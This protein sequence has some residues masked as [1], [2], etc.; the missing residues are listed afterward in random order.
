MVTTQKFLLELR[1]KSKAYFQSLRDHLLAEFAAVDPKAKLEKKS[2]D[3]PGGG[4]GTM[5]VIRGPVV[6]KAGANF[7]EVFGEKYPAIE[8]KHKDKPFY[9]TGVSTIAHMQNPHAPIGHMNLRYLEVGDTCWYGGGADLTPCIEYEED[10]SLFHKTLEKACADYSDQAYE[11]YANWCKEYFFIK[12]RN[13]ERGVG[14]IFFDY[15]EE[16]PEKTFLFVQKVG[17]A[18]AEAFFSILKKRIQMTYG[19]KEK[20]R[21]EYWRGRYV[22]FNLL[23]DRGTRFG[24]MTG[25][26]LDAIFVSLP[27]KVRW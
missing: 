25:G 26:N 6:E 14:G 23:Y 20:E 22:E 24:L 5:G 15:L 16:E 2:W 21:Q 8:G 17:A 10:T 3:R 7:S 11:K 4:G 13:Q 18:Y 27:P 1:A 9:A 12:H 19:D